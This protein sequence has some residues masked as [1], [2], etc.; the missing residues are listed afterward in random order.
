MIS[1]KSMT[2]EKFF[3]GY[4][5]PA[6]AYRPQPFWSFNDKLNEEELYRQIDEMAEQGYGGFFMHSRVG[7]VTEYL[8]EEWFALVRKCA[9]Y[10]YKKGLQAWLYDEDL[11]PSGFAG[12]LVPR[13][14]ENFL[15]RAFQLVDHEAVQEGDILVKELDNRKTIVVRATLKS[16]DRFNGASYIDTMNPEAVKCFL[17]VT[18]EEYFKR[19][20][21]LFGK[22]I[23]GVFTDEPGYTFP[24]YTNPFVIYSPYLRERMKKECGID[25]FDCAESLFYEVGDYKTIRYQYY[26]CA[27]EQFIESYVKQYYEWCRAHNLLFTG[28]FGCEDS[29]SEMIRTQGSVMSGYEFMSMPGIDKLQRPLIQFTTVKQLVSAVRQL[30]RERALCECFA[31]IGQESGFLRRKNIADWLFALG[32]DFIN[33]HLSPYSLRGERKRDYPPALSWHQ[34]WWKDEKCFSDYIGRQC[35]LSAHSERRPRVL[36]MQPL[37]TVA[38]VYNAMNMPEKIGKTDDA[39]YRFS[40]MLQSMGVEHDY[41]DDGLLMRH[42]KIEEERF[43]VGENTYE[44]IVLF[45]YE[46]M[47]REI[48]RLLRE[49]RGNIL[50][51]GSRPMV[52]GRVPTTLEGAVFYQSGEALAKDLAEKYAEFATGDPHLLSGVRYV[53]NTKIVRIVNTDFDHPHGF[54]YARKMRQN[55]YIAENM[56]GEI[57]KFVQ[58]GETLPRMQISEGGSITLLMTDEGISDK[59]APPVIADGCTL[60]ALQ[61][62]G[63]VA[64]SEISMPD[65]NALPL[66]YADYK[67]PEV[68][69]KNIHFSKLWHFYHYPLPDGTPFELT[70]RFDIKEM[71]EGKLYA[72][73]ENAE[74]TRLIE[75]NGKRVSPMRARGEKQVLDDKAYIDASFTKTDIT[76]FVK[77]G[78][79]TLHIEAVKVNNI[80]GVCMHRRAKSD[81]MAT[82]AEVAYIIGDFCLEQMGGRNFIVKKKSVQGDIAKNGYPYY[83]GRIVFETVLKEP[84]AEY[85]K[86]DEGHFAG[87]ELIVEGHERMVR[88][89]P[90]YLFDIRSL[91][92]GTRIRLIFRNTLFALL[93]PHYLEGYD[94]MLWIDPGCFNDYT[95]FTQTELIKPFSAGKLLLLREFGE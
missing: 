10:G 84:D 66:W 54:A 6:S 36:L 22:E 4:K 92:P 41:G 68:S 60:R 59:T 62:T 80:T 77:I 53:G 56:T 14:D 18:H 8:S 16:Y 27:N 69:F 83:S 61:K 49:Y 23:V 90:P 32:I 3:A 2:M 39:F 75:V 48:D 28:H 5:N 7:L 70:Y 24:F 51:C 1:D 91:S 13:R 40:E 72:V 43:I 20:G 37:A 33:P 58:R 52:E 79:N 85:L 47:P 15:P 94:D 12:G 17:T 30:G 73:I 35:Y 25:I 11:W 19:M 29:M 93:G 88:V 21:E 9:E 55:V 87:C 76:P 86:I 67:N 89:N 26:R 34:P 63:E 64:I 38:S 31:G 74:N 46:Y 65:P 57:Y 95:K 42:A 44:T 78:E 81:E 71:P 50:I 45:D 82:E